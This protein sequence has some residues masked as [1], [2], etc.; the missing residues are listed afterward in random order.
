MKVA[1]IQ[2]NASADK[3][4]NI[5][6]AVGFV[7]QAIDKK[8]GFILLPEVFVFRG[9]GG[10]TRTQN[11]VAERLPGE[12]TTPFMALA[13]KHKVFIL[14]GSIYEKGIKKSTSKKAYNTSILIN[15]NGEI[16][17]K[18]RKMHLFDAI[19]NG[20]KIRETSF[21]I[22]GKRIALTMVKQFHVGLSICY[23]L[24]FPEMYQRYAKLG[25]DI[26]C[27]PAAFTRQT[28]Q[29]HWEV[30]LRARAIENRCYVLAPNQTGKDGKGIYSY[31]HSM[32]IDPLGKILARASGGQEEIIF[33]NIEKKE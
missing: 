22:P 11:E 29:A 19:I 20:K 28:G 24:R 16:Q 23:D 17:A 7:Q 15:A 5:T 30:L 14:A 8:A 13:K 25:A 21:F 12:S 31:G 1:V 18:Y 9:G 6:R 2:F 26:L 10:T 32:I 3:E 4:K 27:V 33:G